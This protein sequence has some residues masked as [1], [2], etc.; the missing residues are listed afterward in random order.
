MKILIIEDDSN[1]SHQIIDFLKSTNSELEFSHKLSYQSG[2]R[3]LLFG[4]YQLVLLDM[5]L[6]TYDISGHESGGRFRPFAG[7]EL[8]YEIT[9]KSKLTKVIVVTQFESFGEGDGTITNHELDEQLHKEFGGMYG[10]MV[11]YNASVATWKDTLSELIKSVG[12]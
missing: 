8:L 11:Y 2:L 1:K 3:E 9:R 7:R 5:S 6:P 12:A 10:G 4:H